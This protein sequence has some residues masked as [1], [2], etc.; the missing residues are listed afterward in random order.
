VFDNRIS[1][2]LTQLSSAAGRAVRRPWS[3]GL[4]ALAV[5]APVAVIT[6]APADAGVPRTPVW[7]GSPVV[8]TWPNSVGCSG[9]YYPSASCSLPYAHHT[10]TWGNPYRGDVGWDQQNIAS[11]A[12]VYVY[13]A[14]QDSRLGGQITARVERVGL[15]CSVRS[16]ESYESARRRGGHH[17]KVG[18][19]HGSTRVG[20][21]TYVHI[22]AAVSNG[23]TISRWGGYVGTVGTYTSNSC[24]TGRHLHVELY[25]DSNY[26]CYN[27]SWKQGQQ[28]YR[29]N[30]IGYLGGSFASSPR[31]G[32]P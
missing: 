31:Q 24:W 4:A 14:P 17:V 26:A 29:T 3:R 11:G 8:S 16:G 27:K 30:F 13:A 10:F 9:A 2:M 19:Y 5:A 28:M 21:V 6:A 15:A 20:T 12:A 7:I 1:T 23:Q 22:N 25:N 32:C 18:I